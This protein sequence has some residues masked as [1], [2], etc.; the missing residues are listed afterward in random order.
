MPRDIEPSLAE[1][2]FLL[3]A[4]SQG[5][6]LDGRAADA[7]RDLS[8]AFT[9]DEYGVCTV[10]LGKTRVCCRVTAEIARPYTD[11]PFEGSFI[12]NTE[13]SPM[14]STTF[15]VGRPTEDEIVISRLL[16][17]AIR[18]SRALDTESLCIVAGKNCWTI[19]A[20]V[21]FLNHDGNLVDAACIAVVG[22]LLDF[23]RNEVSVNGSEVT[24]HPVT[25]RVPIPLAINFLPITITFWFF[26]G[27][28]ISLMDCSHEE[29]RQAE[30]SMTITL[31][32]TGHICQVSKSGGV[33][34]QPEIIMACVTLAQASCE[35]LTLVIQNAVDADLR[36]KEEVWHG[37]SAANTRLQT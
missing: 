33:S 20:D 37:G 1:A 11:R 34:L 25:E 29:E 18:R 16:E 26:N 19:R 8:L 9:S 15:E 12:C 17:K 36:M 3:S 24:I 30:G 2:N 28:R 10:C 13:L 27:G 7:F 5:T 32:K 23:R 35:S 6:R 14:A 31:D 22:A 21:L 4:L